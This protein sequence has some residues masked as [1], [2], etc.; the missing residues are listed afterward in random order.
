MSPFLLLTCSNC[1]RLHGDLAT[2]CEICGNPLPHDKA[3]AD[4]APRED[5]GPTPATPASDRK[6]RSETL[7]LMASAAAEAAPSDSDPRLAALRKLVPRAPPAFELRSRIE[8][9]QPRVETPA[10][11]E[12]KPE[13]GFALLTPWIILVLGLA[14]VP[15]FS[16][17]PILDTFG[18]LIASVVHELGHAVSAFVCGMPAVPQISLAGH[19]TA[20]HSDQSMGIVLIIGLAI[21]TWTWRAFEGMRRWITLAAAAI[22]YPALALTPASELLHLLSGHGAEL[23]CATVC[24]WAALDGGFTSYKIE[25]WLY[26]SIGWYLVVRNFQLCCSMMRT[27][28]VRDHYAHKTMFVLTNDYVRAAVNVLSCPIENVVLS[29]LLAS[30]LVMPLAVFLWSL[31][32]WKRAE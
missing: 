1:G 32:R 5:R 26:G 2:E 13:N 8:T 20:V 19:A 31:S 7:Q 6:P 28:E 21:G 14:T 15:A 24:L 22:A 16:L 27:N 10:I 29:M 9:D 23:A 11:V 3:Y 12:K 4:P 25:R 30:L 17:V 18:A